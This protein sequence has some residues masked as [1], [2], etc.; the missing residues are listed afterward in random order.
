VLSHEE[1]QRLIHKPFFIETIRP[2][3]RWGGCNTGRSK[4]VFDSQHIEWVELVG[5]EKVDPKPRLVA[6][7]IGTGWG[8]PIGPVSMDTSMEFT[9][10][11]GKPLRGSAA[12]R[13]KSAVKK[14]RR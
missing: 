5:D 4:G 13:T 3:Y 14:R 11:N 12:I 2:E 6:K 8:R 7:T 10:P 1:R 9:L